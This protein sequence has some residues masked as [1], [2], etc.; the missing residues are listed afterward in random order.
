MPEMNAE[1]RRIFD[2]RSDAEAWAWALRLLIPLVRATEEIGSDELTRIM[3]GALAEAEGEAG[4]AR[5]VLES[6]E[7]G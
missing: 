5:G 6:L 3:H 7:A 4:R 2:A 1:D